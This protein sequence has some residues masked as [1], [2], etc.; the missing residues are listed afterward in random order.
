[1]Y[2]VR[3][4]LNTAAILALMQLPAPPHTRGFYLPCNPNRLRGFTQIRRER[5]LDGLV[6]E[7]S[8]GE[9]GGEKDNRADT[10]DE[11]DEEEA[12]CKTA[13]EVEKR[14]YKESF[15][16]RRFVLPAL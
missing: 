7:A 4:M 13:I 15:Q 5:A 11:E 10:W 1:M 16:V 2:F 6:E 3:V 12:K 9:G 14:V 8:R